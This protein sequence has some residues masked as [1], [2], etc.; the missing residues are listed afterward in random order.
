M[1]SSLSAC[2]EIMKDTIGCKA[3]FVWLENEDHTRLMIVACAT[4]V[5]MTG[6]TIGYEKFCCS[7]SEDTL[8]AVEYLAKLNNYPVKTELGTYSSDSTSFASAG[9]P[10]C[11][12]AR[13]NAMGGA[14]IHNNTDTFDRIDPDS[15]MIT[16]NF[17]ALFAEQIANAP[18]NVIPRKFAPAVTE[19]LEQMK[20]MRAEMD[21]KPEEKKEEGE[22]KKPETEEKK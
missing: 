4:A 12:F 22:E 7:A 13:L 14:Q 21:A 8:H 15:F 3:G 17:V 2:L 20:K 6:V 1:E 18:V 11:T 10:A 19:K 9:V 5:D 16:L